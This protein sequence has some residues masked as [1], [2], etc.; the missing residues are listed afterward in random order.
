LVLKLVC[1]SN[2]GKR[3]DGYIPK[4]LEDGFSGMRDTIWAEEFLKKI[5]DRLKDGKHTK[6]I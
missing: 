3:K 4:T 2:I 1:P 6:D 5:E